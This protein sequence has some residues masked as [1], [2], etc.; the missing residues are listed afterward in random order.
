M[1]SIMLK[2]MLFAKR[3]QFNEVIVIIN[4]FIL[5]RINMNVANTLGSYDAYVWG[6]IE[7]RPDNWSAYISVSLAF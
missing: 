1:F 2:N 5:H 7:S 4:K 3:T 6:N